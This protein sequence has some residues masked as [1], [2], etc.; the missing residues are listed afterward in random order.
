MLIWNTPANNQKN[1]KSENE[2]E[3][4]LTNHLENPF[5]Q[6]LQRHSLKREQNISQ[7]STSF[8]KFSAKIQLKSATVE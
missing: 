5:Q 7:E 3:N 1:K 8:K 2:T 6:T 4:G